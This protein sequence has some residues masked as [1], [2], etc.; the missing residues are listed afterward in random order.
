[1]FQ[2]ASLRFLASFFS[3]LVEVAV[4]PKNIKKYKVSGF[5]KTI[6]EENILSHNCNVVT[7][8]NRKKNSN[9]LNPKGN[10]SNSI[11]EN[12]VSPNK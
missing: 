11:L 12:K 7:Y 2:C 3:H 8:N 9:K 4:L 10:I 1:M 6:S 5:C